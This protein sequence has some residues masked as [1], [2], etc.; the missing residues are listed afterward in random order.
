MTPHREGR[1]ILYTVLF[2]VGAFTAVLAAIYLM[3][4]DFDPWCELAKDPCEVPSRTPAVIAAVLGVAAL[5]AG[6]AGLWAN[7][8]PPRRS[9][10]ESSSTAS[11]A[12]ASSLQSGVRPA[13]TPAPRAA[14]DATATV[15]ATPEAPAGWYPH[16][17]MVDTQRYWDGHHWTDHVAP[18]ALTPAS[19]LPQPTAERMPPEEEHS[20]LVTWGWLMA[21]LFP[22]IG[23]IIGAVLLG[24][25]PAPGV[26]VMI[27]SLCAALFYTGLL[28]GQ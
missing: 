8:R 21:L 7:R 2:L 26:G 9:A 27:L 16:P 20:T 1:R 14:E 5:A 3:T 22:I 13:P 4:T 19:A 24:K 28:A 23:F 18:L 12:P 11:H 10:G 6:A 15:Q 25:R 17:T